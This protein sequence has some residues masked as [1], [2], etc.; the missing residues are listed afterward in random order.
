MTS[1]VFGNTVICSGLAPY[2][3]ACVRASAPGTSEPLD[4]G[5]DLPEHD[6]LH[7]FHPARPRLA[8]V[9]LGDDQVRDPAEAGPGDRDLPREHAPAGDDEHVEPL[10]LEQRPD[11]RRDRVVVVKHTGEWQARTAEDD[12]VG[13]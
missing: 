13:R 9:I 3:I 11:L 1:T 4:C 10:A 6:G 2:R 8:Q 7:P 12:R 5:I